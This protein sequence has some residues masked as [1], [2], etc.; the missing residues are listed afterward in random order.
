MEID[1]CIHKWAMTALDIADQ[2]DEQV[3]DREAYAMLITCLSHIID[4]TPETL[5]DMFRQ[6][7]I[8]NR[9]DKTNGTKRTEHFS[10][11]AEDPD[12]NEDDWQES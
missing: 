9:K 4:V 3:T 5:G 11:D 10:A 1:N 8:N 6:V 2:I 12:G 7:S